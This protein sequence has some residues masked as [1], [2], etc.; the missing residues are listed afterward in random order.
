MLNNSGILNVLIIE[1]NIGDF[2]IIEEYLKQEIPRLC[3]VHAKTF[4]LAKTIIEEQSH[5]DVILLDLTLPDGNGEELVNEALRIAGDTPLIVLTGYSNKNFSIK[6]L[7]LGVSDYLLKDDLDADQLYKGISYSIERKRINNELKNSEE[8]Y[9]SLFHSSPI[10][11]WVYDPE[12][13]LFLNVNHAACR[14]YGYS[15]EEFLGMSILQ[16]HVEKNIRRVENIARSRTQTDGFFEGSFEHVKKDKDIIHVNIQ[17]NSI[18]FQEKKSRL[19]VA[20]DVTQKIKAEN[21]LKI[22]EQR[23]K[24]LVQEGSDL[25]CILDLNGNYSYVSPTSESILGLSSEY[26]LNKNAFDFVHEDDKKRVKADFSMIISE[27]RVQ[28]S[29]YRFRLPNGEYR[30]ME[31]VI[32]NLI[33]D[34]FIHGLVT[35]SRD[36]SDRYNYEEKIRKQDS[37][38]R[39]IIEKSSD[40][41]TLITP[42]GTIIF[43]TPSITRIF[44][45]TEEEY[46]GLNV[47]QIVHPDDIEDLFTRIKLTVAGEKSFGN[48]QLRVKAKW[49]EYRWCEKTIT[50]LLNDP[51]VN[52]IVCNFWDITE[53]KKAD[54]RIKE[55]NDRYNLVSKATSDAIWDY[56]FL[57]NKTYIAGT[58]FKHLFKYNIVNAFLE[59]NFWEEKIHPDDREETTRNLRSF[60]EDNSQLQYQ[61]EYRFQRADGSYA[62]VNDRL[63]V[64]REH[65]IPVRI[66][67]ALNDITQKKEEEQH[68]KL[69]QSVIT[70]AHDAVMITEATHAGLT[71]PKVVYVNEALTKMTG[72]TKEEITGKPPEMFQGAKTDRSQLHLIKEALTNNELLSTEIISYTKTGKPY[73]VNIDISPVTDSFGN[74]THMIIIERD[75]TGRKIQEQ[76]R[77][78]LIFELIQNNKDLR[79]FSYI[80]SHNL[81]GPIANL[82]GLTNLLDVHKAENKTLARI[83][84]GIK[85]AAVS[86]DETIKDLSTV[87]NVKDRPSIPKEKISLASVYKKVT[88]QC[89]LLIKESNAEINV[90]FSNAGVIHF[91]KAYLESILLN[92][93]TNAIK[94]RCTET[95]LK[96]D[97][98]TE[99]A[100]NEI[101][102]KF[103]DNGQ[104][105]DTELHKEKLFGLYQRFH[106]NI[107]GKGLG[108]F[109]IKSQMEALNGSI[110]I[111]SELNRGTLFTLHF[112]NQVKALEA[113]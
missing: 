98:L 77:E 63:F 48:M 109:L 3:V 59:E 89:Q 45:Y 105:I 5:F 112:K 73:W 96:I 25:I 65:G 60:I 8:K 111:E 22:S 66:I 41:K 9:R 47:R 84:E 38:F 94:Y 107:E 7:S 31:T 27:K 68:L 101:R 10:P 71:E 30:W 18:I 104:G 81:R 70:S 52:A 2:I 53:K 64:I 85:K 24:S 95:P 58:G 90:D 113:V 11:M 69:L 102:L 50:N 99:F 28:I 79:Q 21:A 4:M 33:D 78:K 39:A 75:I 83:L 13:L 36:V 55:S 49:G 17:S 57:T 86:F 12:T 23:F 19:V 44:G 1:D 93:M 62:Y 42:E 26:F 14:N 20:I 91:N 110:E 100:D 6:T 40:M 92:L 106:Q 32:T 103:K 43:G 54:I 88:E 34:A 108:L 61:H 15:R 74:V 76:E 82:L 97:I 37:L 51:D 16:I 29:P 67:G 56:T 46:L 80:T 87:L 35:N 72:Y